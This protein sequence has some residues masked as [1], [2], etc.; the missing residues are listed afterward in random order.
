MQ[1]S[2]C[3]FSSS[4][5]AVA[6][7]YVEL[8]ESFGAMLARR[9]MGLVYGGGRVGLMGVLARAVHAH[10]GT[11]VG[12]IPD[13]LRAQEVAYEDADE[14]IIT[15]DL[16]ERKAIMESRSDAFV[17]LPG[18][19]GTLEEI[20]EILTLKQLATHAKP[21]VF[22]N[23]RGFFDPLLALFEQL[24]REQFAKA[25]TRDHYHVAGAAHEALDHIE[26]YQPPAA[27]TKWFGK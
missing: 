5:D 21:V 6:P 24:Y 25:Q 1:R 15:R 26:R 7:H 17:A 23:A 13:F 3:V 16:R 4:S 2:I 22:L 11:V 27:V 14:L 8:A 9:Q 12:V 20:L 18:G 19:F 10:G